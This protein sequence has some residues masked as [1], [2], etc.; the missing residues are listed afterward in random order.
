MTNIDEI[1]DEERSALEGVSRK[2]DRGDEQEADEE[3]ESRMRRKTWKH[4]PQQP[5]E[6]ERIEHE[7]TQ[8]PFQIQCRHCVRCR[9]L[10]EYCR[11]PSAEELHVRG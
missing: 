4:D 5:G 8:V 3:V 11:R 2:E 6:Q 9:G 7:M 10:E 1:E